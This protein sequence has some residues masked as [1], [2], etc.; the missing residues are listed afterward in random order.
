[1]NAAKRPDSVTGGSGAIIFRRRMNRRP[2]ARDQERRPA[3]R[4]AGCA[5]SESLVTEVEQIQSLIG[6][7]YDAAVDPARW[8]GAL[9]K[10]CDFVG[11]SAATLFS[12]DASS[13]TGMVFYSGGD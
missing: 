12:K 8:T 1:M 4:S 3:S 9:E 2:G 6:D 10:T 13:K 5:R 11:G 7:V